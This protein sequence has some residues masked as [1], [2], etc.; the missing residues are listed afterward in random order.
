MQLRSIS[1]EGFKS[2]KSIVDLK[3]KPLNVIIGSNDTG[4]SNFLD[5]F[6]MLRAVGEG[7]LDAWTILE[8][9]QDAVFHNG[10]DNTKEIIGELAFDNDLLKIRLG[11]N[12][13]NKR[14]FLPPVI[15]GQTQENLGFLSGIRCYPPYNH[16][17]GYRSH[18]IGCLDC[19]DITQPLPD[20]FSL[21]PALYAISRTDKKILY[22]IEQIIRFVSPSFDGFVFDDQAQV[23]HQPFVQMRWKR[24]GSEQTIALDKMSHGTLRFAVLAT[25]LMQPVMPPMILI[26]SPELDLGPRAIAI[27]ADLFRAAS[28]Q[29]QIIVVTQSSAL[30]DHLD[31]ENLIVAENIRID[32]TQL[33]RPKAEEYA[34]WLKDYSLGELWRK[35]VFG[36]K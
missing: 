14:I 31:I 24:K 8:D 12:K 25:A 6:K 15:H 33:M 9:G 4:K 27:L 34:E 7:T 30:V 28:E 13:Y 36:S 18:D 23:H 11:M 22:R 32:G 26:E 5:F 21:A 20:L 29:T 19:Y 3:M 17:P 1:I 16:L 35:N 2:I 10:I